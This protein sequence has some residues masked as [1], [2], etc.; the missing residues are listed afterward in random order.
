[1]VSISRLGWLTLSS[2]KPHGSST[3]IWVQALSHEENSLALFGTI[4]TSAVFYAEIC[5]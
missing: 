3:F 1:L 5:D 4:G 2:K